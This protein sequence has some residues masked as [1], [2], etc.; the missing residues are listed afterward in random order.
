MSV[1]DS[2][3]DD[4]RVANSKRPSP[5]TLAYVD[6]RKCRAV[7][8][9]IRVGSRTTAAAA[10]QIMA[11]FVRRRVFGNVCSARV[12]ACIAGIRRDGGGGGTGK[13]KCVSTLNRTT[14]LIE[15]TILLFF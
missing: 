12:R 1:P 6:V 11:F 7:V 3:R 4:V 15:R 9:V 2:G 14:L 13:V 10:Q 5:Y 8:H